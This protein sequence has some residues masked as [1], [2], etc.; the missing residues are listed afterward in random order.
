MAITSPMLSDNIMIIEPVLIV[1][2]NAFLI[3][4]DTT[5]M[6]GFLFKIIDVA[7]TIMSAT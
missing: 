5:F 7:L 6:D 4:R 3:P 1:F 2:R